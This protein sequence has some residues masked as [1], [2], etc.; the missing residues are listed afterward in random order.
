M[1]RSGAP[2]HPER[3]DIRFVPAR[4]FPLGLPLPERIFR[5][6]QIDIIACKPRQ[7]PMILSLGL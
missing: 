3:T 6:Q 7:C 1:L 2:Q 4:H 5:H